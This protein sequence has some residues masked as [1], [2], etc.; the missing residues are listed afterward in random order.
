MCN[1]TLKS[2]HNKREDVC[3]ADTQVRHNRR[4]NREELKKCLPDDTG[5]LDLQEVQ[6]YGRLQDACEKLVRP[7]V[8]EHYRAD[9]C[10]PRARLNHLIPN[11]MVRH[12]KIS[13]RQET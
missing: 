1:S 5:L 6:E 8:E 4:R 13:T 9:H 10:R 11:E 3:Q 12:W 2:A 7:K